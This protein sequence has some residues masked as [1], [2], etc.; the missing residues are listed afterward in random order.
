M[1]GRR[2]RAKSFDD[3]ILILEEKIANLKG[4]LSELEAARTEL[5]RQR[6]EQEIKALYQCMTDRGM[7]VEDM[8]ELLKQADSQAQGKSDGADAQIA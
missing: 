4:K 6:E 1:A 2:G 7:S 3:Q 8:Y 5:V